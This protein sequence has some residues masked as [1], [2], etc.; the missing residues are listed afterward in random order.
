MSYSI[1]NV[2]PQ[3]LKHMGYRNIV[4]LR[5]CLNILPGSKTDEKL[6]TTDSDYLKLLWPAH[7]VL[8]Y[9]TFIYT[10]S[11]KMQSKAELWVIN[12]TKIHMQ[13]CSNRY[14]TRTGIQRCLIDLLLWKQGQWHYFVVAL[15]KIH[16]SLNTKHRH[17]WLF[18]SQECPVITLFLF[19][20]IALPWKASEF[21]KNWSCLISSR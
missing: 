17:I 7:F 4:S 13:L 8:N 19:Y 16:V 9:Y 1:W 18:L 20:C 6:H 12:T 5:S 15:V 3:R 2:K 14:T 21:Q 10:K 11:N